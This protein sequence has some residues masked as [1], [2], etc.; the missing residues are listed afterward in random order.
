MHTS[1]HNT[2]PRSSGSWR[3]AALAHPCARGT[4][5]SMCSAAKQSSV[6]IIET[7]L[8]CHVATL[9]AMTA[10]SEHFWC[11]L[12]PPPAPAPADPPQSLRS[13]EHTSELQSLMRPSYA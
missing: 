8:D 13:E 5:T 6:W 7:F 11:V 4:R 3:A 9:L 2:Q 12:T 1:R 10:C